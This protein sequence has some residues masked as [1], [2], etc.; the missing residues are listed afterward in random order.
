MRLLLTVAC[1]ALITVASS[2]HADDTLKPHPHK[3]LLTPITKA[4]KGLVL[5]DAE[6]KTLEKDDPVLRQTKGKDGGVGVAIRL[7]KALPNHIWDTILNY[8]KYTDWVDNVDSCT[9]YKNENGKLYVDMRTS[10]MWIDNAVFTVNTIR[11]DE[12]Y[13]TWVLDRNRTSD[14]QD[15]VGY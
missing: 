15:M 1:V 11:K 10:I 7:V 8:K 2:A 13:M 6:L 12:G 3:P 5:N 14:V 9:V 4:P